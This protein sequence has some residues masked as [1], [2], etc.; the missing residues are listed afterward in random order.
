MPIDV[1][2]SDY[3][4]TKYPNTSN[5]SSRATV[6]RTTLNSAVSSVRAVSLSHSSTHQA[7]SP[8]YGACKRF[9]KYM[10]PF[11][12][13]SG[14][15]HLSLYRDHGA[16]ARDLQI[17][18]PLSARRGKTT[19]SDHEVLQQCYG[20]HYGQACDEYLFHAGE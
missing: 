18:N 8:K 15:R 20:N 7:V 14:S 19:P 12:L 1:M 6:S 3:M 4:N 9:Y 17:V 11:Q 16:T 5:K 10:P 2:F 13:T